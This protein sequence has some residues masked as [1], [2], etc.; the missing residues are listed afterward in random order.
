MRL[1]GGLTG[2]GSAFVHVM[3]IPGVLK[4]RIDALD[5][6]YDRRPFSFVCAVAGRPATARAMRRICTPLIGLFSL[7]FGWNWT[8]PSAQRVR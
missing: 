5:G 3:A 7:H 6:F 8:V 1:L 4:T 2:P